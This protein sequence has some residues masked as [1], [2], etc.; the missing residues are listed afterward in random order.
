MAGS[1]GGRIGIFIC[2]SRKYS[3]SHTYVSLYII[4]VFCYP[5][6]SF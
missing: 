5:S 2:I 4:A 3:A 1:G 6:F